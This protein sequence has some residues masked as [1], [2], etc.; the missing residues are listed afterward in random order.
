MIVSE[1]SDGADLHDGTVVFL[2]AWSEI[3]VPNEQKPRG[4]MRTEYTLRFWSR[5]PKVASRYNQSP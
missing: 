1:S 2:E 4:D 3:A 5:E